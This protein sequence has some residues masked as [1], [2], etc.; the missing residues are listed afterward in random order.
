MMIETSS[1]L[2]GHF[3]VATP[4]VI[5]AHFSNSV[6]YICEQDS[7]AVVG[8]TINKPLGISMPRIFNHLGS[9]KDNPCW[10]EVE[11]MLGGPVGLDQGFIL[12]DG[13]QPDTCKTKINISASQ[14]MLSAI[15]QGNGPAD[16]IVSVGYAGW[17]ID[18]LQD[19]IR[20]NDWLVVPISDEDQRQ[21][22]FSLPPASRWSAAVRL[23][24]YE[25]SRLSHQ[26]G[27]A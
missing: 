14:S 7:H 24:G 1:N 18:Q 9:V 8:L 16:F 5:D 10:D 23:L 25:P 12:Y 15:A 20:R 6:V 21:L 26:V 2:T 11:V 3:L 17:D 13:T 27:H 19:E 22:L 4:N